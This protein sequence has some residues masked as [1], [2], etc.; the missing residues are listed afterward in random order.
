MAQSRQKSYTDV[1][2]RDSEFQVDNRVFLKVSPIVSRIHVE[3]VCGRPVVVVPTD[4]ITVKDGLTYKEIPVAI[5]DRQQGTEYRVMPRLGHH[6][7]LHRSTCQFETLPK[8]ALK[9]LIQHN[10]ASFEVYRVGNGLELATSHT[11][12]R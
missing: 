7:V 1:R 6:K 4:T 3:K 9:P 11:P 10:F 8:L 5:L 2:R 12:L